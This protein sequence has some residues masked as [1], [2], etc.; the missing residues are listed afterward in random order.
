QHSP[1]INTGDE[2][3]IG[4]E[5]YRTIIEQ[6]EAGSWSSNDIR[7]ALRSLPWYQDFYEFEYLDTARQDLTRAETTLGNFALACYLKDLGINTP[8]RRFDFMED[9]ENIHIDDV[10]NAMLGTPL[11]TSLASV[12]RTPGTVTTSAAAAFASTIV[13]FAS[14]YYEITVDA[15]V[16]SVEARFTTGGGLSSCIFQLILINDDGT[17]RDIYRTDRTSYTKQFP[18]LRDGK[19]LSKVLAVVTGAA[20]SGNFNLTVGPA[21][22]A[23]DVMVTRWHS[24]MKNEYEINSLNWAWTWVSPD[25]WVDNDLDGLADGTVFF[26]FDNKLHIRLHNKGNANAA[27]ISVDFWYQDASGG[28]SNAG[29]LPVQDLAGI[30]QSLGGLSLAAGATQD[31]SVDWSPVP[32]GASHHFCI[33]AV[34][35]VPGDPN[36]DN[37]RVLSNFGN[38]VVLFAPGKFIDIELLRRNIDLDRPRVIELAVVPRL[39]P[40]LEIAKRDLINQKIRLLQ[41]GEA[42]KDTLRLSY[43][44][45]KADTQHTHVATSKHPEESPCPCHSAAQSLKTRP[46]VN[47]HYPVD[48]RT[49]PPGVAGKPMVTIVHLADG[50]PVGGVT[51]MVTLQK[52]EKKSKSK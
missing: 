22:A 18:N 7:Q 34:V 11:Q 36:T 26:N 43:W 37:K 29:W 35:T 45:V 3:L 51:L 6:C 23:P 8:D 50:I 31:W 42:V 4:V 32:S 44:P 5:T 41:P 47:G 30:T 21:A 38:V 46:D 28:L 24:V 1:R 52:E 27:G 13:R 48:P 17:V 16:V 15:L 49:L 39:T 12:A 10:I 33:R 25:I 20:S 9:E 19:R 40:G 2:P 14:R